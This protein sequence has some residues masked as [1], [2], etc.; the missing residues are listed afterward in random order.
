MHDLSRRGLFRGLAGASLLELAHYRAAWARAMAPQSDARLFDIEK[1]ADGAYFAKARPG[2]VTNCNAAIF[3]NSGDVLVVDAHSKPS[4]AAALIA[5]IKK[6]I[7]AKP[8]R[9]V[10]NTHFH[11]DHTQG[12]HAYRAA[13]NRIDFIASEPTKK[14]MSDLAEKRLQLSLAAVPQQ[15]DALQARAS[16]SQSAAEKAWCAERIRQLRAYQAELQNYH[17]ELPTI[18]FGKTYV[19]HDKA[20]DLHLE[21]HGHAHTGGDVVVFC[22]QARAVA[23]GD[24]ILG[25]LPFIADGFPRAWP[26][27]IDSVGKLSFDH[28]MPGHGPAQHDRR[29]MTNERNYIE[30]LAERVATGKKAGKTAAELQAEIT[31]E[32]L[33]SIQSNRYSEYL[34]ANQDHTEPNLNAQERVRAGVKTNIADVFKNIDR[35]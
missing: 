17:L 7:T 14:L 26:K 25:T 11:W 5:Q 19:L 23:T 1:V 32:S 12:N 35:V 16:K 31:V 27:T 3:E 24:M 2:A 20:H 6:E 34:M 29:P 30:E 8:V 10:V 18:T 28:V 13:E 21:Y 15:V 4:A 9:Y 22:P 33:K